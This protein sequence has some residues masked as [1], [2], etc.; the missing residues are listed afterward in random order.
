VVTSTEKAIYE[1]TTRA[2]T[3]ASTTVDTLQTLTSTTKS[4]TTSEGTLSSLNEQLVQ[5]TTTELPPV[6]IETPVASAQLSDSSDI[7]GLDIFAEVLDTT[8]SS[9]T[10]TTT[11][12][13]TFTEWIPDW[14]NS[15]F[16]NTSEDYF[17]SN[18]TVLLDRP[19]DY[20]N[21]DIPRVA[22]AV[23]LTILTILIAV[24][25]TTTLAI[26]ITRA[27]GIAFDKCKKDRKS[28]GKL[29]I[30]EDDWETRPILKRA[31]HKRSTSVHLYTRLPSISTLDVRTEVAKQEP[32]RSDFNLNS[33]KPI[34]SC[35][36]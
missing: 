33:F 6:E 2:T 31:R 12:E 9:S 8:T 18:N 20:D 21:L 35:N 17:E 25:I 28:K 10:T 27:I 23:T 7:L 19:F 29:A 11:I 22:L 14:T 4:S 24:L 36:L 15:T 34:D 26:L 5:T 3:F 1:V 16:N 32:E 13:P 30:F